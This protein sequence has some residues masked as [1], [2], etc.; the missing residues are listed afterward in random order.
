M[1]PPWIPAHRPCLARRHSLDSVNA[2]IATER[3]LRR[4]AEAHAAA[5]SDTLGYACHELRNPLH[6][7]GASAECLA[8]CAN[9]LNK[10]AR[11]VS[12]QRNAQGAHG[13]AQ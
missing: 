5:Q 11:L 7:L 8:D 9:T 10:S 3:R 12:T 2:T 6:A 1:C 13:R 4:A